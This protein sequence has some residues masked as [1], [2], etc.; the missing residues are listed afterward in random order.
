[1]VEG[2]RKTHNTPPLRLVP[3]SES[4]TTGVLVAGFPDIGVDDNSV[5]TPPFVAIA[6]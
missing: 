4:F 1:M 2:K 3:L 6:L 5:D